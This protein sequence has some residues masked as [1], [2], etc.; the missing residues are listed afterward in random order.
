MQIKSVDN[1]L[2]TNKIYFCAAER[3]VTKVVDPVLSKNA[4][5][6]IRDMG[7]YIEK[8]WASKRKS[9]LCMDTPVFTIADSNNFVT[10]KPVYHGQIQRILMEIEGGK[11]ID[12]LMI[13][14][15]GDRN[16]K[17]ERAVITDHGS[18]TLRTFNSAFERN[19]PIEISI[20][21]YIEK[22]FPQVIPQNEIP[23]CY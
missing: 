12:R 15:T 10:I 13:D 11:R 8:N 23:R 16:V 19:K 4:L 20:N 5:D 21:E 1:N 18:A 3:Q 2:N 6:L 14:R 22:Y 9:G 17:Y 7:F